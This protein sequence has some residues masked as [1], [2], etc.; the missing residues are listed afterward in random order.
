VAGHK[1]IPNIFGIMDKERRGFL[2]GIAAITKQPMAMANLN[3]T[4]FW[5]AER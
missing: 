4:H 5:R 3:K 1:D 2:A